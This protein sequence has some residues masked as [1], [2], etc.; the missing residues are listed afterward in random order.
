MAIA[1]SKL[2]RLV[3]QELDSEDVLVQKLRQAGLVKPEVPD[4]SL[5]LTFQH[6]RYRESEFDSP[7][8]RVRVML[9]PFLTAE[10]KRWAEP[11]RLLNLPDPSG[12]L[13]DSE[14]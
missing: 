13:D 4:R 11:L 3:A 1:P 6:G 5:K 14:E 10:G 12:V 8:E 9:A 2:G 7:H